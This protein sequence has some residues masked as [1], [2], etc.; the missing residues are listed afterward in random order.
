MAIVA[1]RLACTDSAGAFDRIAVPI[2]CEYL[3][4]VIETVRYVQ[5]A[6]IGIKS[7]TLCLVKVVVITSAFPRVIRRELKNKITER[8][9]LYN[10][11]VITGPNG[12]FH[13]PFDQSESQVKT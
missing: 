13:G 3:N 11:G 10:S 6:A 8:I 4:A 7:E 2:K 1:A 12:M 5:F 9:I